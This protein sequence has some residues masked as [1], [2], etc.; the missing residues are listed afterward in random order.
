MKKQTS[1]LVFLKRTISFFRPFWKNFALVMFLMMVGQ[2]L[3]LLS[4]YVFGKSIDAVSKNINMALVWITVGFLSAVIRS[5]LLVY[6]R[7]RHELKH[8]DWRVESFSSDMSLSKML[9]FSIGQHL[10]EHSGVKQHVV[11]QGEASVKETVFQMLYMVLPSILQIVVT[12][13]LLF[14]VDWIIGLYS[15]FMIG[16]HI[17][18][19]ALLNNKIRKPL[20]SIRS[21]RQENAKLNSDIYRNLPLIIQE[22]Q[23]EKAL[24]ELEKSHEKVGEKEEGLWIPFLRNH[25][26]IKTAIN[27]G[28]FGSMAIAAILIWHGDH[29]PGMFVAFYGWLNGM[30][31][32]VEQ[33]SQFTRRLSV[34]SSQIRKYFNLL[35]MEPEIKIAE[36]SII[37]S[38]FSGRIEFKN[39]NFFY[40]SR[41]GDFEEDSDNG[42]DGEKIPKGH[43]E[44]ISDVS[45]II[46]SGS[47]IGIVG[48]S[49][50]GKTTVANLLR[51][52]YDPS[53]GEILIDDENL[54]TINLKWL[55]S[56]IGNVEQDVSLFDRSI[57]DNILYGLNGKAKFVS[58]EQ[59]NDISKMSCIYELIQELEH[60]YDTIIGEKGIKLSGGQ[61]QRLAIARALVKNPKILIFDEATSALDAN[62][63]K[64][65]QESIDRSSKGRTTIIIAHRLSTVINSDKILVMDK[66]R[67]VGEGTHDELQ[68]NCEVYRKLIKNQVIRV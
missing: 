3:G 57:R 11:R 28:L 60:G 67:L 38:K 61:R 6:I 58:I 42:D 44:A 52:Y 19:S 37:I 12:L 49:G 66:G 13:V 20:E 14:F 45:F 62:N 59:L 16:T 27:V 18:L 10:N 48:E 36:P 35:E 65:I 32:N 50:S 5:Q 51:R 8:I 41:K 2:M 53:R 33:I 15:L 25:Y 31:G 54:T 64:L 1:Y 7:E 56:Q 68:R 40:P 43:L 34:M 47:K 29:K 9:K 23:E 21:A 22:A 63:E 17:F 24:M 26:S 39:V 46:E 30:F 4:P 55:R